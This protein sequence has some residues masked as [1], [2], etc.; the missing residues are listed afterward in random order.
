[1]EV[2]DSSYIGY[3]GTRAEAFD[4][5]QMDTES[6]APVAAK[7]SCKTVPPSR[8]RVTGHRIVQCVLHELVIL[9]TVS[10]TRSRAYHRCN[11]IQYDF[12]LGMSGRRPKKFQR[13]SVNRLSR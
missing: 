10:P 12:F 1:V 13:G 7:I 3:N 4:V 2:D 9:Q 11:V 6:L 5:L 8:V